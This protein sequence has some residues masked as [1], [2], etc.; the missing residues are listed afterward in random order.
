MIKNYLNL[1]SSKK[2]QIIIF[3]LLNICGLIFIFLP[4]NIFANMIDL[5]LSYGIQDV[6]DSFYAMGEEGRVINIY[7]TLILDTIYP[8]LYVSLILGTYVKLFSKN[9][10]ILFV[11]ILTGLF[12][13][14]EN[15][16]SVIMN[17]NYSTLDESQVSLASL[18]TSLKWL[19]VVLM[20]LILVFG[21]FK[22]KFS[23]KSNV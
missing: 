20:I 17:L 8:I 4:H 13:L 7:S 3:I 18:T 14:S 10:Y 19:F 15:I 9:G 16:Q 22:K 1:I 21:I 12:D 11:P 23:S 2:S 5:K 6:Y